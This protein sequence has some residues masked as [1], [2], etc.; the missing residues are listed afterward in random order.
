MVHYREYRV[1]AIAQGQVR[2]QIQGDYFEGV[3]PLWDWDSVQR[4]FA[5]V[6]ARFVLLAD[7]AAFDV[8]SYPRPHSRP[9]VV[10]SHFFVCL[11]PAQV[12][13]CWGIMVEP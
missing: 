8:I 9:C 3:R 1:E 5:R 12:S 4:C 2:D 11:I 13:S 7:P 10:S 6:S